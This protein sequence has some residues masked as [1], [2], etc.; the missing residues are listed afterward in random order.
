[1]E[2]G[3]EIVLFADNITITVQENNLKNVKRRISDGGKIISGWLEQNYLTLNLT[4]TLN[5]F[6]L[7]DTTTKLIDA[8]LINIVTMILKYLAQPK[9]NT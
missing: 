1:M 8:E 5:A 3:E 7:L 9:P 6:I 2:I 4:H